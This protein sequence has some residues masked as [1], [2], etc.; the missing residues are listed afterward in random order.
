[1]GT[2]NATKYL[3]RQGLDPAQE[4]EAEVV[5]NNDP[6]KIGRIKARIKGVF[7]GIS[8]DDLPWAISKYNHSN[9]AFNDGSAKRCG[10]FYVPK[11]KSKVALTFPRA[12]DSHFCVYSGYT[13][14]DKTMLPESK[15]NY[16]DRAVIRF[17]N[18]TF[19]IIDTKTNELFINNP[20]DMHMTILGSVNQY[21]VGNQTVTVTNKLS[22]ISP[23]LLNAPDKILNGLSPTPSNKIPF[24]GLLNKTP[25]GNYHTKVTGDYTLEVWGNKAEVVLGMATTMTGGM[26]ATTATALSYDVRATKIGF[27]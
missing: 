24:L 27:N 1:M 2:I 9:G 7:D 20:G 19:M 21:I 4:Y 8:D 23:Y 26:T 14:D 13:V 17:A 10:N 15:T 11:V 22:D 5:N 18:G 16:P 25:A 12:G 6:R 3:R